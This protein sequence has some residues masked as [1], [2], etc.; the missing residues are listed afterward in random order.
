MLADIGRQDSHFSSVEGAGRCDRPRSRATRIS[1]RSAAATRRR[2]HAA[3]R[4]PFRSG[5]ERQRAAADMD[6]LVGAE[7]SGTLNAAASWSLSRMPFSKPNRRRIAR[8]S[9]IHSELVN[10]ARKPSTGPGKAMISERGR[11]GEHLLEHMGDDVRRRGKTGELD[12]VRP[13]PRAEILGHHA[14]PGRLQA[15]I[16]Q[17]GREREERPAGP[18]P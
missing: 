18:L 4:R 5:T 16:E 6:R 2:A 13:A 14:R 3:A 1:A 9:T 8:Q 11:S 15:E 17:Q 10:R 12:I 7:D